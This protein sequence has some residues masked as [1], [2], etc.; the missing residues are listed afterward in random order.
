MQ[1]KFEII[2][3]WLTNFDW[4]NI[5]LSNLASKPAPKQFKI[6][7]FIYRDLV[8]YTENSRSHDIGLPFLEQPPA[9]RSRAHEQNQLVTFVDSKM[10]DL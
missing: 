9:L 7:V 1:Q 3:K 5:S 4:L 10:K 6:E 8:L 2:L